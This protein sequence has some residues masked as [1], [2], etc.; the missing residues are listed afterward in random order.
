MSRAGLSKY[1]E[2]YILHHLGKFNEIPERRPTYD[3]ISERKFRGPVEGAFV[4]EPIP[5]LYEKIAVFDFTSMHTSI[6]ISMN[7]SKGTLL[8]KITGNSNTI[9]TSL[10]KFSFTKE[11]GFLSF[12]LKEIFDTRKKFKAEYKKNPSH[13][14]KARSNAF[15][16]LS[17][18]VHG[19]IAFF[20]ARYYSK[21][22]SAS[23]LAYVRKFNKD[24]IKAI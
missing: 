7:I 9:K 12:L 8:E 16:L 24:A 21:E 22:S 11:K 18:S 13:I 3:Q 5:G 14:T 23:I 2:S 20:G 10:G 19:Y 17:A 4:L 15:K 1:V 6:I